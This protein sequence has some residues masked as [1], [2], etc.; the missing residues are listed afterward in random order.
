MCRTVAALSIA[1][2][3]IGGCV[4]TRTNAPDPEDGTDSADPGDD[5]D[6]TGD[7]TEDDS[8]DF[9]PGGS[10][11]EP[12]TDMALLFVFRTESSKSLTITGIR[13]AAAVAAALDANGILYLASYADTK[14]VPIT[15]IAE[16]AFYDPGTAT[17]F[18]LGNGLLP[19]AVK[20]I[21]LPRR[22]TLIGAH[23]FT[24]NEGLATVSFPQGS[25]LAEIGAGAFL[26]SG[27]AFCNFPASLKTVGPRA[28]EKTALTDVDLRET[29]LK[30]IADNVFYAC[31]SLRAVSF[32]PGLAEIGYQAFADC[33]TLRSVTFPAGLTTIAPK[34]FNGCLVLHQADFNAV[35]AAHVDFRLREPYGN[36]RTCLAFG[37]TDFWYHRADA[38]TWTRIPPGRRLDTAGGDTGFFTG[39]YGG[40]EETGW[41]A[42]TGQF[43]ESDTWVKVYAGGT[44]I[45]PQ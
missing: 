26:A 42:L 20:G 33:R 39:L 12:D 18:T 3:L 36:D 19:A 35:T 43:D 17:E 29:K 15:A 25:A 6:H 31:E 38:D 2:L 11:E 24:H 21:V 27:V 44:K 4:W 45:W 23:A 34:A 37:N 40:L 1:V 9:D 28:F 14:M 13:D 16:N 32:P 8:G 5:H 10:Y 30:T 7:G 41:N 22:L